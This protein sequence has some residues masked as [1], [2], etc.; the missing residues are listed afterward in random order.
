V[1]PEI[2]DPA[3]R[4]AGWSA[5]VGVLMAAAWKVR[6]WMRMDA[7]TDRAGEVGQ[8][9]YEKMI[10]SLN[11]QNDFL[12]KRLAQEVEWRLEADSEIGK[13]RIRVSVLERELQELKGQ[14]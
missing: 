14:P 5:I 2:E 1:L 7:R 11:R 10:E 12:N 6:L 8:S 9:T 13:L 4:A 3:T